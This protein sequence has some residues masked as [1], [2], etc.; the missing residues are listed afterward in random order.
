M[1]KTIPV[2]DEYRYHTGNFQSIGK[3]GRYPNLSDKQLKALNDVQATLDKEGYWSRFDETHLDNLCLEPAF[4][5]LLR[6][7]RATNFDVKE[8]VALCKE[9]VD[10]READERDIMFIRKKTCNQVLQVD[11]ATEVFPMFPTWLQNFDKQGRPVCYRHFGHLDVASILKKVNFENLVKFHV[12]ETEMALRAAECSSKKL[13]RNIE[14]LTVV[15]DAM[16][17]GLHL[18]TKDAIEFIKRM[19]AADNKHY[20]ERMGQMLIINAPWTLSGVWAMIS[21]ILDPVT[22]AKIQIISNK[23]T[24]QKKLFEIV[25]ESNVPKMFGG[26]APDLTPLQMA[27]S[28]STLGLEPEEQEET[29]RAFI[30]E[31]KEMFPHLAH[32][33]PDKDESG[34]NPKKGGDSNIEGRIAFRSRFKVDP[35]HYH[36]KDDAPITRGRMQ[37]WMERAHDLGLFQE[38]ANSNNGTRSI[39]QSSI[40]APLSSWTAI[41][42]GGGASDSS[43]GCEGEVEMKPP[44]LL[45]NGDT[46]SG[47]WLRG[48]FE[49][50]GVL[51]TANGS[52]YVG[53]FRN[54]KFHGRGK[55]TFTNSK[56]FLGKYGNTYEGRFA[57]GEFED[58]NGIL[59]LVGGVSYRGGFKKGLMH[60]Q[61]KL[62]RSDGRVVE[63]VFADDDCA[64]GEVTYLNHVK[65]HYITVSDTDSDDDSDYHDDRLITSYCGGL[66]NGLRHGKGEAIFADGTLLQGTFKNDQ[67]QTPRKQLTDFLSK[68]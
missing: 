18:A 22:K 58:P 48:K 6:F 16:D 54:G 42:G 46:Y 67:Y 52:I 23:S 12:F 30:Q 8:S 2:Q 63:G 68:C 43:S 29:E 14:S 35:E 64:Q 24:W 65:E 44:R 56:K 5:K 38:D 59:H 34:E 47:G 11:Y 45:K 41:F 49:G 25:D 36:G 10:W 40:F 9:N 60:G 62:V 19:V 61:G 66:R 20:V 21:P 50:E 7:L 39:Y 53:A 51:E 55:Y 13:G 17:W 31:R 28:F 37:S 27:M 57:N 4:L 3:A 15:V 33:H 32:E 26:S 1:Y